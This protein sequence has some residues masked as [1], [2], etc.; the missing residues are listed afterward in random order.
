MTKMLDVGS[1]VRG[2][3]AMRRPYPEPK[4][5]WKV[6]FTRGWWCHLWTP[7]WHQGRGPYVTIGLGVLAIYRGY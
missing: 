5:R 1:V 3:R 2:I 4:P 7:V 6:R